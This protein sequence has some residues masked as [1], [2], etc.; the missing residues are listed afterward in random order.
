MVYMS[1]WRQGKSPLA[2]GCDIYKPPWV[3]C[4]LSQDLKVGVDMGIRKSGLGR[5]H[6]KLT[7]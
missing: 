1:V 7:L 4:P 5:F 3:R 2:K 6:G